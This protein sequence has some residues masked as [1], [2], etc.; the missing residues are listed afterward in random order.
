MP[1]KDPKA[2]E[3]INRIKTRYGGEIVSPIKTPY[4]ILKE[5]KMN[6]RPKMNIV[7]I[8]V[9]MLPDTVPVTIMKTKKSIMLAILELAIQ[10]TILLAI[11]FT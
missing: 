5:C 1:I 9:R 10:N 8:F 3:L 6:A 2:R 4:I 7:V 11:P